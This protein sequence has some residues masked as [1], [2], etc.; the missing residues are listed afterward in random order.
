[1]VTNQPEPPQVEQPQPGQYQFS[2]QHCGSSMVYHVGSKQLRCQACGQQKAIIDRLEPIKELPLDKALQQLK[3]KPL[4]QPNTQ[5]TCTR[6]GAESDWDVESL[7]DLCP[8]CQTPIA[9]LDTE[10]QR[11]H[12]EAIVP[13]SIEK[14]QAFKHLKHWLKKR[15]FAP[16]VLKEM[17][18]HNKQFEGLYVPHWTFDSLTETHYHGLRGVYYT[19]YVR[20]TRIVNG[21]AQ[22]VDVPIVRTRW[23]PTSG[24]V[25]LLFDDVLVLASM[26]IPKTLTHRLRPWQLAQAVPYTPAYLAGLK[27]T[28]YQVDL[29][30]AFQVAQR[31]M[32][33][34]IDR[35]IRQDIGGDTQQIH[36]KQTR[37]QNSTYKLILLP[38][39][40]SAFEY[41]G[42]T[43]QTIINGQTGKVVGQYPKSPSKIVIAVI[44]GLILLG[45]LAYFVKQNQVV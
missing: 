11:L 23:F 22:T 35:A 24:R 14:S 4:E 32:A 25:S 6:C 9:K 1:M 20:R 34:D 36:N 44:A 31:R 28:Y 37:Y 17:T 12:I 10:N 40:H 18:G 42:K 15:W 5:V 2:C 38:V 43:Y 30:Q 45:I 7:S 16:N 8:Y 26:L 27:S 21:K 13:F 29:N 19:E 33:S 39:W 41:K 3:L